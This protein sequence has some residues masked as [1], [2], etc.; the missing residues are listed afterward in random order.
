[1]MMV[2]SIEEVLDGV[3]ELVSLPAACVR[4]N[5][6]V[7]DPTSSADD[8]SQVITQDPALTAR[9]LRIANSPFYGLA[10]SV[11]TVARAVTVLG[12]RQVRDLA[13]ATTAVRAFEGIPNKLVSM[14][15]FWEHSIYSALAA[16]TLAEDCLKSRRESVFVAGL[17]HDVGQLVLY[18]RLPDLSRQ[19]LEAVLD[20]P[21]ELE[22][23][24]A[25]HELMGFDHAEVGAE[26]MRRWGLPENL[27]EC[28]AFHHS[29]QMAEDH[30]KEVAIIHIANSIAS[31]AE[32]NSLDLG[33]APR[34]DS[35][36]WEVIGLDPEVIEPTIRG[37]QAQIADARV[38]LLGESIVTL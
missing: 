33:H 13:L 18:N 27:R 37:V 29:P 35:D 20:G 8:I 4:I 11:D 19:S 14:Q 31:M 17:L 3:E 21:E 1:M 32:L 38:L 22:S 34:I 10:S 9:L 36:A 7:D 15:S 26:L 25:E 5:E 12:M 23:Q 16:R 24:E 28:V 2:T 30:P 6:M